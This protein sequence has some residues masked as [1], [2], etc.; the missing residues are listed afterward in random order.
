[1]WLSLTLINNVKKVGE[2][3]TLTQKRPLDMLAFLCYIVAN[4]C[5]YVHSGVV[6]NVPVALRAISGNDV[7]VLAM[8]AFKSKLYKT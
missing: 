1:M 2:T 4:K 3:I 5:P 6:E 7:N 8:G